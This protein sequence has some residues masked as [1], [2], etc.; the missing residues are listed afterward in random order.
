MKISKRKV[1]SYI[2]LIVAVAA[3]ILI[4]FFMFKFAMSMTTQTAQDVQQQT[5]VSQE[6][7]TNA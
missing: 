1:I 4:V 3:A 6:S 7:V 2:K 5:E